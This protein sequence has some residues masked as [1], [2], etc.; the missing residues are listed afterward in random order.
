MVCSCCDGGFLGHIHDRDI[1]EP[2]QQLCSL[3]V[4]N[5]VALVESIHRLQVTLASVMASSD[6]RNWLLAM[7]DA[8]M[9]P[10]AW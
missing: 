3:Q 8:G 6:V 2:S 1:G 4:N 5:V 10:A 9:M 7:P